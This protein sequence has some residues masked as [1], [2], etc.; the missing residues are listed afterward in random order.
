MEW[1]G[2]L[3]SVSL[4]GGLVAQ[5]R[6]LHRFSKF[7]SI[8]LYKPTVGH[9]KRSSFYM[10]ATNVKSQDPEAVL[11]IEHRKAVWRA[12]TFGTDEDF[13]GALR[14]GEASAEELLDEFGSVLAEHARIV[15]ETQANALAQAPFI[16]NK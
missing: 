1:R 13:A 12:A 7:S 5:G 4:R 16:K 6:T 9:A 2:T 10:V 3:D 8:Q 15:W 14:N 11:A